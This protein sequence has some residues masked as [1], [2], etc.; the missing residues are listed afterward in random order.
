MLLCVLAHAAC[1]ARWG[2]DVEERQRRTT[3][4]WESSATDVA[5]GVQQALSIMERARLLDG[6]TRLEVRQVHGE[7]VSP[8]VALEEALLRTVG[9]SVVVLP[10]GSRS[11]TSEWNEWNGATR[12]EALHPSPHDP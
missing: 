9:E 8:R 10:D 1:I 2:A 6:C 7:G 5:R 4:S 3:L 11:S 12:S